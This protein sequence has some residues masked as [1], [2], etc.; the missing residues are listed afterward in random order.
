[1]RIKL[2]EKNAN[3]IPKVL[4]CKQVS[5]D[6]P[7]LVEGLQNAGGEKRLLTITLQN[8]DGGYQARIPMLRPRLLSELTGSLS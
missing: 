4:T 7:G 8:H 1:M 3:V 2:L 5:V 6:L